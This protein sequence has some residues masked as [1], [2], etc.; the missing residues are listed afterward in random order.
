MSC[1]S[2]SIGRRDFVSVKVNQ[3]PIYDDR[4]SDDGWDIRWGVCQKKYSIQ[5]ENKCTN[6]QIWLKE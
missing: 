1:C 2:K 4:D 5:R 6:L 3:S